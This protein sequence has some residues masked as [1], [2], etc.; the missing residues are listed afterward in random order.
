[1][2]LGEPGAALVTSGSVLALVTWEVPAARETS[3][4]V[5]AAPEAGSFATEAVPGAGFFAT[6]AVPGVEGQNGEGVVPTPPPGQRVCR[7]S[8][9]SGEA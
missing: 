3:A 1:M 6:E 2:A 8:N 5:T 4:A 9:R 7:K